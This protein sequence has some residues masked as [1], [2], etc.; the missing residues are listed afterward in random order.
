[1]T[2]ETDSLGFEAPA[3]LGHPGRA[4][5]PPGHPTG[6]EVGERLPDFEL[7]DQTG[8]RIR[9]HE[10]R[11]TA[12]AAVVFRAGLGMSP[13]RAEVGDPRGHGPLSGLRRPHLRRL[14]LRKIRRHPL[15]FLRF[16]ANGLRLEWGARRRRRSAARDQKR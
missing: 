10:H 1:M 8:R 7:L 11:G 6:P 3:P 12:K 9:F 5:L 14:M 16:L 4:G 15:G 13:A 2:V